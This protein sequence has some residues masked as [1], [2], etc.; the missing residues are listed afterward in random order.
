MSL[1][2]FAPSFQKTQ[3]PSSILL[4]ISTVS[5]KNNVNTIRLILEVQTIF[6]L[7]RPDSAPFRVWIAG[8]SHHTSLAL[9]FAPHRIS[10]HIAA[11]LLAARAPKGLGAAT[12][13]N[14]VARFF[15]RLCWTYK[16]RRCICISGRAYLHRRS[17]NSSSSHPVPVPASS[18]L[19]SGVFCAPVLA[20]FFRLQ[21]SE[22]R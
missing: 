10:S 14:R 22:P 5:K 8:A 6:F 21:P 19:P 7:L 17:H 13:P 20:P 11:L 2:S 12:R 9:L 16:V 1:A 4:C 3:D 15:G 18:L